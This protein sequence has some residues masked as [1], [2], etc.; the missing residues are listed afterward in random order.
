MLIRDIHYYL[1]TAKEKGGYSSDRKLGQALDYSHGQI[2]MLRKQST[3]PSDEKMI[4]IAVL[5]GTDPEIALLDLAIWRTRGAAQSAYANILQKLVQTTAAIVILAGIS[6]SPS[7][8]FAQ[9]MSNDNAN[10]VYYGK[11]YVLF[12][13]TALPIYT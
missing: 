12:Y 3:F 1:D 13:I 11:Y 7:P 2:S 6:T 5:S 10:S 4:E 8:T 9:N